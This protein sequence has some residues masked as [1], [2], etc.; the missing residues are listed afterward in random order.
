MFSVPAYASVATP[1]EAEKKDTS[2]I[3]VSGSLSD[4]EWEEFQERMEEI[5]GSSDE[6]GLST[7]VLDDV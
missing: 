2:N 5:N 7:F 3:P 1:S 4:E 6:T